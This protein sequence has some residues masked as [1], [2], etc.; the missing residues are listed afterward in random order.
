[1]NYTFGRK[2]NHNFNLNYTIAGQANEQG[3]IIRKGQASTVQNY[4]A[5]HTINFLPLKMA[6]NTSVNYTL[7][8]VSI[9]NSTAKG[10]AI[11]VSKKLLQ[12]KLNN[13]LGF[14]YN[15]TNTGTT[16]NSVLGIKYMANYIVF[17]K[18]NFSLGAIQMFKKSP[19][20]DLNELTLNFNYGYNF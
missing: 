1:M 11:S 13:N 3:G 19:T 9:M 14:L 8:T 6:L 10:G 4:N 20:N 7:N 2:K 17:K 15:T 5:T 18:H 16:S 12:D